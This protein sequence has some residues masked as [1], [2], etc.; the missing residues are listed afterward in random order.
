MTEANLYLTIFS[1]KMYNL[2][3]VRRF[4]FCEEGYK[5]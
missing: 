3:E 1:A 5:A 4:K 2:A